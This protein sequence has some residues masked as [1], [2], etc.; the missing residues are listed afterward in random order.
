MT[1]SQTTDSERK[2]M[3]L[4]ADSQLLFGDSENNPL[5]SSIQRSLCAQE[6]TVTK[7]AYI[8][9]SNGDKRE[10]FDLFVSAMDAINTHDSKMIL[11]GFSGQDKEYLEAADLIVLAGGDVK[12]GWDVIKNTGMDEII[13]KKFYAGTVMMGVSAGAVQLGMGDY[14]G[15]NGDEFVDTLKL[16]PYYINVHEEI[17]DWSRL[18]KTVKQKEEYARGYGIP[19]GGGMIYHPD[20]VV[21]P[22]RKTLT[23]VHKSLQQD[24]KIVS[25][26]LLA[27]EKMANATEDQSET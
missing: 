7:V 26:I 4:L 6:A 22:V 24:G 8:G 25:N 16:I 14:H 5:I 12:E 23:E 3:Y 27:Q 11:S 13:S 15:E 20:L 19:A 10:F 17:S 9:A 18:K 21:E 2:P 1:T